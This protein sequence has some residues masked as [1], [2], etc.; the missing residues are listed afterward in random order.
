MRMRYRHP[1]EGFAKTR[2]PHPVI[3]DE[4]PRGADPRLPFVVP[5]LGFL[6]IVG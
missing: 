5:T 1:S 6:G 2:K 3:P 4:R